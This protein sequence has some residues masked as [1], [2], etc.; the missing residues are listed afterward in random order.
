MAFCLS[1]HAWT[2][3]DLDS[4]TKLVFISLCRRAKINT[5]QCWPSIST[6]AAD[7]SLSERTVRDCIKKLADK[8]KPY[9]TYR[10]RGMRSSV[11]TIT[12]L[13]PHLAADRELATAEDQSVFSKAMG[14][15]GKTA[16][17]VKPHTPAN[18]P[19]SPANSAAQV[20]QILPTEPV[21]EP[22]KE[23][24]IPAPQPAPCPPPPPPPPAKPVATPSARPVVVIDEVPENLLA[25]WMLVR[26]SKGRKVLT[27]TELDDIR[28]QATKAGMS[29]VDVIR[30]CVNSGWAR[31][32]AAWV[33]EKVE[34]AIVQQISRT[35]SVPAEV[36][37]KM[38]AQSKH[39]P[40]DKVEPMSP[41][42]REK[43][44]EQVAA[45]KAALATPKDPLAW[46]REIIANKRA[47]QQVS[48][49]ALEKAMGA[50]KIWT[51]QEHDGVDG[52]LGAVPCV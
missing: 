22:V 35:P 45:M 36:L 51:W 12:Y 50:L 37:E 33:P 17:A 24:P 31:F 49:L 30:E 23:I 8:S 26:K 3:S 39:E 9:I 42:M 18:P 15:F 27:A 40:R 13:P 46:A 6:I 2:A 28:T 44:R 25:D 38:A 1:E 29:L 19:E 5:L 41:E 21:I 32:Q 14:L 11:Y 34:Q 10:K 16:N 48:R 43:I 52:T 20:R 7:C 4:S 47:G